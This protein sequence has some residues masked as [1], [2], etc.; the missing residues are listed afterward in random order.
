MCR[1]QDVEM[2]NVVKKEIDLLFKLVICNQWLDYF[3]VIRATLLTCLE[4]FH[5][6][7]FDDITSRETEQAFVIRCKALDCGNMTGI[8]RSRDGQTSDSSSARFL[9]I[10]LSE[11]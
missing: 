5:W 11:L 6:L 1:E 8:L 7:Q 4:A 2:I 3:H 10:F 9:L